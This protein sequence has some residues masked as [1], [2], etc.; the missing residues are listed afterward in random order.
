[1]ASDGKSKGEICIVA[2]IDFR[3]SQEISILTLV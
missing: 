1:M 3:K 2:L